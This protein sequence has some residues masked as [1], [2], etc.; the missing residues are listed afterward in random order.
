[1]HQRRGDGGHFGPIVGP[2]SVEAGEW[3]ASIVPAR[4]DRRV[5]R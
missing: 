4:L 5:N 2:V 3:W 1:V